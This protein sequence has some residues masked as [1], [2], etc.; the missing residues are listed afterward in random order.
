MVR[1]DRDDARIRK[2]KLPGR[3]RQITVD[4]RIVERPGNRQPRL[5]PSRRRHPGIA[6]EGRQHA[7][8]DEAVR[9][10]WR[11]DGLRAAPARER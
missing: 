4:A 2:P 6:D 8:I 9:P 10:E 5:Q 11:P 7:Q 3:Q 1:S